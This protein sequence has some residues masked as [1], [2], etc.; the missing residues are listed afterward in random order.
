MKQ[1]YSLSIDTMAK[2][3]KNKKVSSKKGL[4]KKELRTLIT[5]MLSQQPGE[6][7]SIKER[8]SL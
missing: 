4:N 8:K 2:T 3:K 5:Q 6:Y 7:I 1:V